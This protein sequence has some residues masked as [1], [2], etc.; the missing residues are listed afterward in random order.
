MNLR[1]SNRLRFAVLP[2]RLVV[3]A[4]LF[5]RMCRRTGLLHGRALCS[6]ASQCRY[7]PERYFP[8]PGA[9][10]ARPRPPRSA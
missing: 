2:C 7:R 9:H 3:S 8:R 6:P 5:Q 10:A 4:A 1:V